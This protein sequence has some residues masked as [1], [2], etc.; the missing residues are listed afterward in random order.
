VRQQILILKSLL[1]MTLFTNNLFR[2]VFA[3]IFMAGLS[4]QA[5]EAQNVK[6]ITM[7][8]T[9]DMKFSVEKITAEPGQKIEVELTTISDFPKT[10]MAHN[11]VLL[12]SGVDATAV[13]N[14]SARAS[15]N[16][17]IAPSTTGKMITYSGMAGAGETVT[18]TFTAPEK[19]GEY[20]YICTFPGHYVGGMKGILVVE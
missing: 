16:E 11:F 15:D 18:V 6:T 17:Y 7:E 9:D 12:K 14:K 1:V 3:I 19:P 20:E 4:I 13:A 2:F 8:G 5:A 10:A